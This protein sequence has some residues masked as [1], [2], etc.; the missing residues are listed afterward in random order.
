MAGDD[1]LH[2]LARAFGDAVAA[3]LPPHLLDRKIGGECDAAVD[4]H[5]LVGG[6]E[7]HFVGVIFGHARVLA[8]LFALIEARRGLVD[9]EPRGL[10]FDE[11]VGQH[12]LH[13]LAVGERLA[14]GRTLLGIG[15]RHFDASLGDAERTRTVLDAADI[16][17][18]LAVAH[19]FAF[20]ADA[21]A[22]RHAHIV[23]HD[24]PRLVAHHGF[25]A[26][27]E[28]H[29]RRIHIHDEAGNAAA[30]ALCAVG[31]DHELHEI[32]VTGSCDEAPRAGMAMVRESSSHTTA[33]A[34]IDMPPPPYSV[35]T[36]SCQM[37]SS[38]ARRSKRSRYFGL[39]C[40]PSVV[41]RSIGI[42]SL[43]TKRRRVALRIRSSSGNSKSIA[44]TLPPRPPATTPA[45][46]P[47]PRRL[48]SDSMPWTADRAQDCWP[49]PSGG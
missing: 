8:R 27:P 48:R 3:L 41:S 28:L 49:A 29:T 35:G 2:H 20:R 9:E 13:R 1:H 43:S 11:H 30:R 5:A 19:A 6:F 22:R 42:S 15:S 26:G 37:P 10:Q 16:E 36:S 31:R 47:Q 45:R 38:L 12:P 33:R 21:V 7:R 14:E 4:L 40:S 46:R 39:I 25:I 44:F 32:G 34:R 23:E 17:P 24:F 18:L